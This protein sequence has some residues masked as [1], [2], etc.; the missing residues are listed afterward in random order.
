MQRVPVPAHILR[1]TI[2]LLGMCTCVGE[3][4]ND[5]GYV[6]SGS[7]RTYLLSHTHTY[8]QT[9]IVLCVTIA[10]CE[11]WCATHK[12]GWKTKCSWSKSCGGCSE[13]KR[14]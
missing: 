12:Q 5:E 3:F 11:K 8:T 10:A 14:E 6:P 7:M 13:C 1:V 4:L 9:H 2:A